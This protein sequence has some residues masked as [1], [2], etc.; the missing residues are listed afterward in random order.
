VRGEVERMLRGVEN[1]AQSISTKARD[2][3]DAGSVGIPH[4]SRAEMIG[5]KIATTLIGGLKNE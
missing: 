2:S 1:P 4:G 5:S 3:I